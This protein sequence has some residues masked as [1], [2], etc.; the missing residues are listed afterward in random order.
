MAIHTNQSVPAY[1]V[2]LQIVSLAIAYAITGK[3][4]TL[5]AIPPGYATA[6]WP[7]SGIALAGVLVLGYRVWPGVLLGA[8]FVNLSTTLVANSMA[9]VLGSL[10]ITLIMGCGASLQAVVG[11]YLLHR[12]ADFPNSL[13]REREVFWF[14]LYGGLLSAL[15]NSSIS[16]TTLLVTERVPWSSFLTTWGTWWL[17]DVLGIFIFCPLI[18]VWMQRPGEHWRNRRIAITLP[19]TAMFILTAV[20]VYYESLN[21]GEHIKLEFN[22]Q[23]VELEA[24]L[25][26]A[27]AK[28]IEVLHFL[29]SFYLASTKIERNDFHTYASRTLFNLPGIQA[30]EW[31]PVIPV[32]D[33]ERFEA[34]NRQEGYVN[35]RITERTADNRLEPALERAEYVPVHYV[36][37]FQGNESALGYD[38]N[39]DALRREALNRARDTGT[40]AITNRISLVQESANQ[41]GILLLLPVYQKGAMPQTVAERRAAIS[42]FFIVV[43]RTADW[44]NAALKNSNKDGLFFRVKDQ[45]APETEQLIFSSA[46]DD[47]IPASFEEK[48]FF[49]RNFS[50]VS[51]LTLTIGGR[52]WQFEVYPTLDYFRHH[53]SDIIWLILLVGLILTSLVGV[54]VIV[55]S[56]RGHLLLRLVDERTLALSKSEQRFRS[57]F[58]NVPVGVITLSLEGKFLAVNAGF[59]DLLEYEQVELLQKTMAQVTHPDFYQFDALLLQQVLS[60]ELSSFASEKK[61]IRKS[62]E[63]IWCNLSARLIESAENTPEHLVAV[64]ENIDRRKRAEESLTKLSLA[65]EQ[66]PSSVVIADLEAKIEYVNQAFVSTTGYSREQVLGQNPRFLQSGKTPQIVYDQMWATLSQGEV[67]RGELI[68]KKKNGDEYVELAMISPVR[69]ANGKITHYLGIKEDITQR[70]QAENER[71]QLLKIITDAPDF[72]AMTDMQAQVKYLNTAGAKLVGLAEDTDFSGLKI[73]ALYPEWAARRVLAEGVAVALRQG[74]WQGETALLHADGYE[75]PVAQLLLLHRDSYG[76]PVLLSTIMRDITVHK[77]AEQAL[78][79]AKE[80]AEGLAQSRSEFIANMSHEIRTP[81]NAIVGLSQLA[82]NKGITDEVRD[83]LEKICSASSSL[84]N[85]LNDIL[86]FSKLEAGRL[87]IDNSPFDLD[88]VMDTVNHLF[89]DRAKQKRLEFIIDIAADVPRRLQGDALRLQQVLINLMGNAIKF[90]ERGSVC[91]TVGVKHRELDLI[92]LQFCVADTGIGIASDDREKLFQP[93]SQVDGS[94][95]RRFGGTGLGLVISQNLLHL[96]GSEF[97]VDSYPGKGSRFAFDLNFTTAAR[98]VCQDRPVLKLSD[99]KEWL[100]GFRVLVAEDNIINQQVVREFLCLSGVVVIIANNGKEVL[101]ILDRESVDAVLMDVHMPEMDG[102]EATSKIRSQSRFSE[103]PIIALTAGVTSEER[104]RCFAVG[105][106]DFIAKPIDPQKLM[107]TLKQWLM[108]GKD[109]N[110]RAENE[111]ESSSYCGFVVKPPEI[112]AQVNLYDLYGFDLSNLL[113]MLSDNQPLVIQLLFAFKQSMEPIIQEITEALV[114]GELLSAKKLL[115]KLKGASGNIGAVDLYKSTVA[116]E[117]EL[118]LLTNSDVLTEKSII[119]IHDPVFTEFSTSFQYAMDTIAMLTLPISS[120]QAAVSVGTETLDSCAEELDGLLAEHE[121]VPETVLNRFMSL[122]GADRTVEFAELR[123]LISDLNYDRA[124]QLLQQLINNR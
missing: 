56:G 64:V 45:T 20:A 25:E 88:N 58:E 91:L 96:M 95:T 35:L 69:Q 118:V 119:V 79:Q 102:F 61:F 105:M 110:D 13:T 73:N 42:G 30:L 63:I 114:H 17:G 34:S 18:L 4:G 15:I 44:V 98:T 2:M 106:N 3:L 40:I 57:T 12:Y 51:R 39:S 87:T 48:G 109:K 26:K 29:E 41:Y 85:I 19:I 65:V 111:E 8:L 53:R 33:R 71:D 24:A 116:L 46:A 123:S 27:I 37:P 49:A 94:I 92:T 6:V 108:L 55:S 60:G 117:N 70:K 86:D 112:M 121:F 104:A 11:A 36:E 76:E 78:Q 100:T 23:T 67:W 84:L 22:R 32:S 59:C 43:I 28:D 31:A 103:L 80:A 83:Y 77:Q 93:F 74:F 107:C 10:L 14:F 66:S 113:R 47:H 9:E 99:F 1:V 81:M 82:L 38:L 21:D 16:V 89:A 72:I 101:D 7:P 115:H 120:I 124:R 50:L 54:F 68:N 5:L 97:S 122:V 90:T 75:I 62:G 52:V